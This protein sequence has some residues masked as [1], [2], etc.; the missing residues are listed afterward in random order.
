[1]KLSQIPHLVIVLFLV[2][3][4]DKQNE[5]V[6]NSQITLKT[7]QYITVLGVAQDAGFPQIDCEKPCC[8]SF[9]NGKE[10]KKLV[11][12][13]GLVDLDD[14]K[15]WIFDATPDITSQVETLKTNHLSNGS[16]VNGVFLTHAHMGHYTGLMQ[17]GREAMNANDIPVYTMPKMKNFIENNQPWQQLVNLKNIDLQPLKKDSTLVLNSNLKVTPFLVPHRDEFSE[18]VGY[19]IESKNKSALFIPDINKW[20]IWNKQIVEEVKKVDYAFLDATFFKDGE[21]PRPM[22]DIPHPFIFETVKLFENESIET[23]SKIYFIHL[24]HTNPALKKS[25]KLKDSIQNLG[26]NFAKEGDNFSL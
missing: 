5:R 8:K 14:E 18:T 23:K 3:C 25:H 4:I 2:N 20:N 9:Y 10:D 15:K 26:F 17:L 16:I 7:N 21:V 6:F 24:N 22:S 1:M 19:K 12:C 11:S 13:L